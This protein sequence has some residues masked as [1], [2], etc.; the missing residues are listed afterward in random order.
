MRGRNFSKGW[1]KV[2]THRRSCVSAIARRAT[3]EG[4]R[5]AGASVAA[6]DPAL[7]KNS[8][9]WKKNAQPRTLNPELLKHIKWA[10]H[11]I[12]NDPYREDSSQ[13]F[14]LTSTQKD[15]LE[16]LSEDNRNLT[17]KV[18]K[19]NTTLLGVSTERDD[20]RRRLAPFEA[21]AAKSFPNQQDR[22]RMDS[23]IESIQE[24]NTKYGSFSLRRED[25]MELKKMATKFATDYQ[26]Q[27]NKIPT[28]TIHIYYAASD[29]STRFADQLWSTFRESGWNIEIDPSQQMKWPLDRGLWIARYTN[30]TK[31]PEQFLFCVNVF[32][33]FGMDVKLIQLP[34]ENLKDDRIHLFIHDPK[35]LK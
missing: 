18:E 26:A 34:E 1:K 12:N 5:R 32:S 28:I 17:D 24:L 29:A 16:Q 25:E 4:Y 9:D 7:P 10:L 2:G 6:G 15:N 23:L 11:G 19:Q 22:A 14:K 31:T 13:L 20:L 33:S 35:Y 30:L 27:F 8:Q 21:L 3:A